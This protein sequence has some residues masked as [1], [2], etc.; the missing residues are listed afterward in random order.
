MGKMCHV[1]DAIWQQSQDKHSPLQQSDVE[2]PR[3]NRSKRG[4]SGSPSPSDYA[5]DDDYPSGN[6]RAK[7][8]KTAQTTGRA[9]SD[10]ED[11]CISINAGQLMQEQDNLSDLLHDPSQHQSDTISPNET[12]KSHL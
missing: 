7:P 1:L 6:E 2:E 4:R 3:R 10:V 5:E 8:G 12:L 11:D 9:I